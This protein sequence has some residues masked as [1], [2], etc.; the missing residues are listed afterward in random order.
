MKVGRKG[1]CI[2]I[3][4]V[5]VLALAA[6][7]LG[8]STVGSSR[9]ATSCIPT[10]P[11][12]IPPAAGTLPRIAQ[13]A[14]GGYP[15]A[16]YKS[17]WL[18]FKAK[19]NPPWTI[20]MSNNQG[21]LN[22]QYLLAGFNQAAKAHPKLI[23]KI[24]SVTPPTPNDVATQIQQMRSL[25]Q[26]NVD[27]IFSTL[28]SPTALNAV[29]AEAAKKGVPVISVEGQST[30]KFAVNLQQNPIQFGYDGAAGLVGA[31]GG[32][33]TALIVDAIPGLSINTNILEG[34]Q[35]VL[36]ACGINVV[37]H[38]TG[39]FDPATAKTAVLTFLAAHPGQ[40]IDGAFEV[41][42][43]A[44]G[45]ISAFQQSGKSVPPVADVGG[46]AASLAYWRD[47]ADK[48]YN[49]SGVALPVQQLGLY[50][51]EV[52]L[53]MLEGRGVR[54]TDVPFIAPRITS[55]NLSQWV[56]PSWTTQTNAIA[57]KPNAIPIT[58]LIDAY[59]AKKG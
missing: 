33:G 23:K 27:I 12:A 9:S 56:K 42:L 8:S 49:G 16:V 20:G 10:R 36:D 31:M 11:T 45:V 24:I 48:G 59:F 22:A 39:F 53:A 17:P 43:M 34:A 32:K 13:A 7:S 6:S 55:A 52:G 37:G 4:T 29:I 1:L 44:P 28:G 2:A 50:T 3:T 57:D 51:A 47:N 38:V 54:V 19:R 15:G 25:L 5:V 46:T 41:A 58:Q 35:R 14:L 40:A 30:S 18:N 21:N 26:Q